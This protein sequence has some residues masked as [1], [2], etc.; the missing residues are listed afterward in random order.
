[1]A[2]LEERIAD[3][4]IYRQIRNVNKKLNLMQKV[5]KIIE[6]HSDKSLDELVTLKLINTDQKAQALK[7]PHLQSQ[8]ADLEDKL[9]HYKKFDDE[10]KQ[11]LAKLRDSLTSTHSKELEELRD[12]V[13]REAKLEAEIEFKRKLLTF[14]RFLKAAAGRRQNEDV[15]DEGKAFE[16][17]L[18]GVYAGDAAA[19][20]CAEKLV[21]GAEEKVPEY[22]GPVDVTCEYL[23]SAC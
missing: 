21:N 6:E 4:T 22:S 11:A 9:V 13:T 15:S 2:S 19:V 3:N 5:D 10:H 16:G 12:V 23:H 18:C 7:K 14:T 8:V 1:M 20:D 17:V